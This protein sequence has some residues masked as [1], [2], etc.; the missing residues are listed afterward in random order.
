MEINDINKVV[1]EYIIKMIEDDESIDIYD[2][3]EDQYDDIVF[4][5]LNNYNSGVDIITEYFGNQSIFEPSTSSLLYMIKFIMEY[6]Q[7]LSCEDFTHF[8]NSIRNE[9]DVLRSYACW[10]IMN[11]GHEQFLV[12]LKKYV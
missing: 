6:K 10:Y 7:R 2:I 1:F 12:E 5:Y 8:L 4:Y 9:C 11:M 3:T